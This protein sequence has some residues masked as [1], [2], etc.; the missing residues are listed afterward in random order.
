[1]SGVLWCAVMQRR[2]AGHEDSNSRKATEAAA[3]QP[4]EQEPAGDPADIPDL[5]NHGV[6]H[7]QQ[8][9]LFL[10]QLLLQQPSPTSQDEDTAASKPASDISGTAS[11]QDAEHAQVDELSQ[12]MAGGLLPLPEGMHSL[13]LSMLPMSSMY[14]PKP[15]NDKHRVQWP[16]PAASTPSNSS[17]SDSSPSAQAARSSSKAT[18]VLSE[19]R[20][21]TLRSKVSQQDAF[22]HF[23]NN[24]SHTVRLLWISYEGAEVA[25]SELQPGAE[26][27]QHTFV[28]HPWVAREVS[29]AT[30]LPI[31]MQEAFCPKL[32]QCPQPQ[33]PAGPA[34]QQ[35]DAAALAA[36]ADVEAA[37]G[38][39]GQQQQQQLLQLHDQ[40][41]SKAR[42]KLY[43]VGCPE[44][45]RLVPYSELQRA[46]IT[47]L[48]GLLWSES[49]HTHFPPAFQAAVRTF[50]MC[51]L[52]LQRNMQAG[53]VLAATATAASSSS[54]SAAAAAA[55]DRTAPEAGAGAIVMD[56]LPMLGTSHLGC[57]PS[58]LLSHIV[59][60]AAPCIPQHM[61][62]PLE[63][64]PD[65]LP[66]CLAEN[67]DA[68][69]DV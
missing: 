64:R 60:L 55:A 15:T 9:Q 39:H 38:D 49:A 5:A 20:C 68:P 10:Q 53:T 50:L 1:M 25:Y 27:L 8:Q 7:Q 66:T 33:A 43:I 41:Q 34:T 63:L 18:M 58:L 14:L 3:Q 48:P 17:N 21:S 37:E 61:E 46:E 62:L 6:E 12:L 13:H 65:I 42:P 26:M 22:V 31:N 44:G 2:R 28:T 32:V 52:Q 35:A 11:D 24:T 45:E 36:G 56:E 23:T 40:V 59:R 69:A 16:V 51:H 30:Q 4:H 54:S 57:L 47:A 67:P 19:P 29:T